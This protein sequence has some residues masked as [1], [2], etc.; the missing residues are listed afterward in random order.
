MHQI[1]VFSGRNFQFRQ[2]V[3]TGADARL[4]PCK[5]VLW[6]LL[7]RHIFLYEQYSKHKVKTG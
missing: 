3:F 2:V 6:L 5:P 4:H 7:D 1:V